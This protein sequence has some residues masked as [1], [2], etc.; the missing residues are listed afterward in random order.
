M[1]LAIGALCVI[2]VAPTLWS[3]WN[4]FAYKLFLILSTVAAVE[5]T[6]HQDDAP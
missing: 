6:M 3:G 4:V 1:P 2:I 5:L